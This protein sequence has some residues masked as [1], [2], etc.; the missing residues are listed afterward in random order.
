MPRP[1][2]LAAPEAGSRKR[3][4][5]DDGEGEH[6]EPLICEKCSKKAAPKCPFHL[7]TACC[8]TG[9]QGYCP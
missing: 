8:V 2:M 1:R 6:E 3:L 9:V 5:A 7:C 4:R